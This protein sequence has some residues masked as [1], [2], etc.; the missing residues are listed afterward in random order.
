[1]L[2]CGYTAHADANALWNI[3][4]SEQ[5]VTEPKPK[6]SNRLGSSSKKKEVYSHK[7]SKEGDLEKGSTDTP[8]NSFSRL[9]DFTKTP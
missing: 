8:L 1:M 7:F 9:F 2:Y 5:F 4:Y 3:A 6:Y